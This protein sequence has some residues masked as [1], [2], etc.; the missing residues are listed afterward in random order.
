VSLP[1]TDHRGADGCTI[2]NGATRCSLGVTSV[3]NTGDALLPILGPLSLRRPMLRSQ[4]CVLKRAFDMTRTMS[5]RALCA[6]GGLVPVGTVLGSLRHLRGT[7]KSEGAAAPSRQQG[8]GLPRYLRHSRPGCGVFTK[9]TSIWQGTCDSQRMRA[10]YVYEKLLGSVTPCRASAVLF[11]IISRSNAESSCCTGR[12]RFCERLLL[13]SG[14][15]SA[16]RTA[17]APHPD[18]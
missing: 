4:L 13:P 17:A 1:Q 18:G 5:I 2:G 9:P 16:A 12:Y 10:L 15:T 8:G 14:Q 6:S 11:S 3:R 7:H